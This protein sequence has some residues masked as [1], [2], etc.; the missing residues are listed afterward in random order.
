[1]VLDAP[2]PQEGV[3]LVVLNLLLTLGLRELFLLGKLFEPEKLL[4]TLASME[5]L[6]LQVLFVLTVEL[7]L[8]LLDSLPLAALEVVHV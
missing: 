8:S 1:M 5:Q 7:C 4:S 6:L 3:V 2:L